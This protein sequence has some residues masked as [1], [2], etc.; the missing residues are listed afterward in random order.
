MKTIVRQTRPYTFLRAGSLAAS[1]ALG[2]GVASA[3]TAPTQPAPAPKPAAATAQAATS[4]NEAMFKRIDTDGNGAITKAELEKADANLARD[5]ERYDTD[6][7]G[8][9]T[10]VEFEAM[11]KVLR[12]G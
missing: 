8:Q 6:K 2:L 4:A 5:F 1:V 12:G 7:D 11:L 3:Q 10:M 9:L